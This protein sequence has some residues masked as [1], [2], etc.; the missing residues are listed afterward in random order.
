MIPNDAQYKAMTTIDKNIALIAGAGT[1][2][3]KVLTD[4]F[5]YMLQH[6][7][8]INPNPIDG[9][10]AITFTKKAAE[11]MKSRIQ[12]EMRTCF[13]ESEQLTIQSTPL[14]VST[15]HSFCG[16]LLRKYPFEVGVDPLFE[17][18]DEFESEKHMRFAF[19]MAFFTIVENPTWKQIV[20]EE[21]WSNYRQKIDG[22]MDVYNKIR[23]SGDSIAKAKERSSQPIFVSEEDQEA[24]FSL[25]TQC[26]QNGRLSNFKKYCA[27][28][29]NYRDISLHEMP[30]EQFNAFMKAVESPL[31]KDASMRELLYRIRAQGESYHAMDDFYFALLEEGERQY[32]E[33]KY[34]KRAL[35]FDDLQEKTVELLNT[36]LGKKV[37]AEIDY[38]FVD[39][40][41][42]INGLQKEIFT[43]L[44]T[45]REPLDRQNL[46]IVG[47][48]RQSIYGFR[49]ADVRLFQEL[50]REIEH[51]GGEKIDMDINYRSTPKILSFVERAFKNHFA[52]PPIRPGIEEKETDQEILF[53]EADEE[54][55]LSE[56]RNTVEAI[57]MCYQHGISYGDM[58][59]L[60]RGKGNMSTVE[61]A[62]RR[63]GIPC[64]NVSSESFWLRTEILDMYHVFRLIMGGDDIAWL[65]FLRSPMGQ[66]YDRELERLLREPGE[67]IEEKITSLKYKE[68]KA[69]HVKD[70]I[71]WLRTAEKTWALDQ[72]FLEVIYRFQIPSIYSD[73]RQRRIANLD[74]LFQWITEQMKDGIT[75]ID[76]LIKRW[77]ENSA[78][79][80]EEA[81][82]G[83]D[84]DCVELMT[85]HKSKGLGRKVII[86]N[87]MDQKSGGTPA[88]FLY[89]QWY[90]MTYKGIPKYEL[91]KIHQSSR[92]QEEE[93][94][95]LYVALT[96]AKEQ[97]IL[98]NRTNKKSGYKQILDNAGVLDAVVS[99]LALAPKEQSKAPK[100]RE[101][102]GR[103]RE[104]HHQLRPFSATQVQ[105]FYTCKRRWYYQYVMGIHPFEEDVRSIVD[106]EEE[107]IPPQYLKANHRG[108]LFHYLVENEEKNPSIVLDE[109]VRALKI[110]LSAH[111]K[112]MLLDWFYAYQKDRPDGTVFHEWTFDW[113][114]DGY[115]WTGSID[116]L[117][118]KE[119]QWTFFDFKTNRLKDN[120]LEQYEFQMQFYALAIRANTGSLPDKAYLWWVPEN[121]R[122]EVPIDE[123]SLLDA[124]A[125]MD[126]FIRDSA[127]YREQKVI[128]SLHDCTS[129]CRNRENCSAF[130][131]FHV[132]LDD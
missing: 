44:C 125:R 92:D 28:F 126:Q 29:S 23:A 50:V 111:E 11:E 89:D 65:G 66:F 77:D 97:L 63:E 105:A 15:I 132:D 39:E 49:Y 110:S 101:L 52:E 70:T 31:K 8:F 108:I 106:T 16:Q 112:E 80:R 26:E 91:A 75:H 69:A 120:L 103:K 84:G 25:L 57:Q 100:K 94:R 82:G 48:P 67:T 129:S 5:V 130:L 83:S 131:P 102:V 73:H 20:I 10:V 98:T 118:E 34:K 38:I 62:L 54:R 104:N 86:I 56:I 22:L 119:N 85:I 12:K 115:F 17:E 68:E 61:E 81:Q 4:R 47:D 117:V 36:P 127:I 74:L 123:K 51:S 9:I 107:T 2:K 19:E 58:A 128:P 40:A 42:D 14:R 116:L 121:E 60:F 109:M 41:Q 93:L 43:R 33:I 24:Y 18:W 59:I 113:N 87:G 53:Y 45:F 124:Q 55:E 64:L 37:I 78:Q 46:F 32:K 96:R 35:D 95:I 13:P 6:G 7:T 99:T 27:A 1:G 30:E 71:D 79:R 21:D 72:L 122:I 114:R 3:T 90:G 88:S 76:P